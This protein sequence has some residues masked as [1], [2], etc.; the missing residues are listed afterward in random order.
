MWTQRIL[1]RFARI[2]NDTTIENKYYGVYNAVLT[3][4]CFTESIFFVEPQYALPVAQIGGAS[5]IDF[6]VTF[7]VEVDEIHVLFLDIK[8]PTYLRH[9][10][11]RAEADSQIRSTFFHLYN[12]CHTP[13]LHGIS[14]IRKRYSIYTMDITRDGSVEPEL[15]PSSPN[16]VTDTAPESRW[17]LD[18]TAVQGYER[19]MA[20]VADVKQMVRE[21]HV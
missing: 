10:S 2:P 14:A 17:D 18:I 12:L 13:R 8:P 9:V 3:D 4:E 16:R 21:L 6:V 20:V 7:I 11:T 1:S 5:D 19:F 15:I